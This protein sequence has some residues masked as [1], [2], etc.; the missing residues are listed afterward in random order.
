MIHPNNDYIPLITTKH[1]NVVRDFFGKTCSMRSSEAST[2]GTRL[3]GENAACLGVRER[4]KGN[5]IMHIDTLR[6]A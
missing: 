2:P 6:N 1:K 5:V 3:E 4:N